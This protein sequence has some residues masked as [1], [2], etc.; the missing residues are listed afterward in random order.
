LSDEPRATNL[1][2][3]TH[4]QLTALDVGAAGFD[5]LTGAGLVQLT[6]IQL[7]PLPAIS[8][9]NETSDRASDLGTIR[10]SQTLTGQGIGKINGFAE[11]DWYRFTTAAGQLQIRARATGGGPLEMNVYRASGGALTKLASATV[12]ATAA[13]L[14]VPTSPG[15]VYYVE[16]K[17]KNTAPGVITTGNY[18]LSIRRAV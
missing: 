6:P 10:L 16:V 2:I 8:D 12:G 3:F 4:L 9:Q 5:D 14:F 17:G 11:Y 13:N 15:V 18:D 7:D 1:D